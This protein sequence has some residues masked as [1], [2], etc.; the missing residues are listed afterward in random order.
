LTAEQN[1][2]LPFS[3]DLDQISDAVR[4]QVRRLAEEVGVA[5]GELSRS[6]SSLTPLVQAPIRL[7]RA[8]ALDPLVLLAEHPT[9]GLP[10]VDVTTLAA[11]LSDVV[12][13]RGIGAVVMTGDVRFARAVG[14]PVL[15]L[16][17]STGELAS[18]SGWRRWFSK[19]LAGGAKPGNER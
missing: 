18:T 5:T 10:P 17:P 3:L 12:S 13:R 14:K 2:T 6:V 19:I 9:A 15:T 16:V 11:D 4:A 8:L 7:G 1:L